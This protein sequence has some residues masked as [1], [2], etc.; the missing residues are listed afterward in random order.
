MSRKL[1][2]K[3]VCLFQ[4]PVETGT[5]E[6]VLY[7]KGVNKRMTSEN[8]LSQVCRKKTESESRTQGLEDKGKSREKDR[9]KSSDRR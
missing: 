5:G 9:G 6:I 8:E 2:S 1:S 7:L 3:G 4:S